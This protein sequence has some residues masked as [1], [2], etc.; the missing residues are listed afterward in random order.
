[1]TVAAGATQTRIFTDILDACR[2]H[3]VLISVHSTGRATEVVDLI[4]RHR[5]PGIPESSLTGAARLHRRT[6]RS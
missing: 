5:H 4:E 1:V 6:A 2:D 3:P